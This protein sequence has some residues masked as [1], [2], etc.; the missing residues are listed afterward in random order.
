MKAINT[1]VWS[2]M[3]VCGFMVADMPVSKAAETKK[4]CV[5]QKDPKTGKEK[6][7]CKEIKVHKKLEGTPVPEKKK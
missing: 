4:S 6:E 3:V 5:T 1:F 2:F 7:V